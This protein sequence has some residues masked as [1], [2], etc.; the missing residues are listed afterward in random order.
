MELSAAMS[1]LVT[2][3]EA[4]LAITLAA[5]DSAEA[6]ALR[7]LLSIATNCAFWEGEPSWV[8]KTEPWEST[9]VPSEKLAVPVR[10]L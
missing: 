6:A 7:A 9:L 8:R 10:L 5:I 4:A 3:P 2:L 1:P